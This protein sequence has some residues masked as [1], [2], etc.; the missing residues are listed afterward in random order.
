MKPAL[1]LNNL[2]KVVFLTVL[3][4]ILGTFS[5]A[6]A[7]TVSPAR[8]ELSG[9]PGQTVTAEFLLV[10]EQADTK[11]F[12]SSTANFEAQGDTGTPNFTDSKEGL[13]SWIKV[14]PQVVLKK[15][16]QQKV[17]FDITIPKDAGAGGHFAAVFL[18]T[19]PVSAD[20]SQVS[21]GAKIGVLVL[22]R[23]S[24]DIK[25]GGGVST[26]GTKDKTSF[27][28]SLPVTFTYH[29]SNTGGDRVNPAGDVIVRNLV[30]FESVRLPA[31]QAQ[32]N[33]LPGSTRKFDVIWGNTEV[34]TKGLGFFA[35]AGYQWNHFA[36]GRYVAHLNLAY[37]SN[38]VAT[39]T[40][41][42]YVFPWQLL[43]L[44]IILLVVIFFGAKAL[45]T[46]Y[47]RWIIKKAK[48]IQ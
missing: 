30:G 37:G 2:L 13:A 17:K 36:L 6:D 39:A 35:M 8:L 11:T 27:Y 16:E 14:I 12:Y 10:N 5:K 31:N 15:N 45:L 24:G 21:I 38:G 22:L 34:S 26:F 43:V 47:N 33:V 25:E 9:D 28:T 46:R 48:E 40:T 42:I 3:V 1:T 19:S 7:L 29:F 32:G 4:F 18:S 41:A 20:K 44:T 23:V